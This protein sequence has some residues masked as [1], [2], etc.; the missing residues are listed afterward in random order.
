MQSGEEGSSREAVALEYATPAKG[1]IPE[2]TP[3]VPMALDPEARASVILGLLFFIPVIPAV[4][5]IV[6]GVRARRR[7]AKREH[8]VGRGTALAGIICGCVSLIIFMVAVVVVIEI[9]RSLQR[10]VC[11]SQLR[12]ISMLVIMYSNDHGGALP[13]NAT[14]LGKYGRQPQTWHCPACDPPPPGPAGT[15]STSYIL[16]TG[17]L[18][19]TKTIRNPS[20]TIIAYEPLS[21]HGGRGFSVFYLDGHGEWMKPSDMPAVL[22]Q[23]QQQSVKP[24]T[25]P[26]GK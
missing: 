13:P 24:A 4:I 10:N 2:K 16:V 23:I 6:L 11:M 12:D 21:N 18:P 26:V 15:V 7:L 19:N 1:E 3:D 17:Q 22:Q 14:A 20:N 9:R 25:M 5:A 8:D